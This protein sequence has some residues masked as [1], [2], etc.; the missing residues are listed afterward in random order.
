MFSPVIGISQHG[1]S[2]I[3]AQAV[4]AGGPDRAESAVA[5]ACD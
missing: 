1:V 4:A 3:Q 2:T 5:I